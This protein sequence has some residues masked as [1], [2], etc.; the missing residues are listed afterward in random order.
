MPRLRNSEITRTSGRRRGTFGEASATSPEAVRYSLARGE[1]SI[2]RD[3]P[4]CGAQL[5]Q[6]ETEQPASDAVRYETR[7]ERS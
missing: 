4:L 3:M 7:I 5:S 6:H 2:T 1:R